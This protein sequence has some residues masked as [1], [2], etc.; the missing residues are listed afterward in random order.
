[1]S[2]DHP[3]RVA[4]WL[5]EVFGGP[6]FYGERY[7]GYERMISQHVGKRIRPEQRAR[8][9]ALMAQSAD[10]AG[11]PQDAEFRAAFTAYL[12]WGSRIALENSQA[13]AHP[14]PGM[15]IPRWWWVCEATPGARVSALAPPPEKIAAPEPLAAGEAPSFSRHIKALFRPMDRNSMKFAF[16]LWSADDVA[17]HGEA[18]LTRLKAGT[19][20]CDGA[21]ESD[22]VALFEQWLEA[23]AKP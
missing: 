11:M 8:W 5:C 4:A 18:I 2:P 1:M 21:W 14:P 6:K 13:D 7:G 9:V 16:D 3:E 10:E 19:M 17:Q 15:P 22:K 12:E 20:P 23:G